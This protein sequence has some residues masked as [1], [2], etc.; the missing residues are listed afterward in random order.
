MVP[1]GT[2]REN[3]PTSPTLEKHYG[4]NTKTVTFSMVETAEMLS[5]IYLRSVVR[6]H[7]LIVS[8]LLKVSW[9]VN[10]FEITQK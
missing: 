6:N 5:Y 2:P 10:V 4:I 7:F 1:H 9:V 3:D 8:E